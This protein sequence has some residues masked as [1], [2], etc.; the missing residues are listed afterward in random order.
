[1][2]HLKKLFIVLIAVAMLLSGA[3]FRTDVRADEGETAETTEVKEGEA[4][5]VTEAE[6]TIEV[7]LQEEPEDPVIEV[8]E[9][10]ALAEEKQEEELPVETETTETPVPEIVVEEVPVPSEEPAAEVAEE[11]ETVIEVPAEAELPA[12]TEETV[13]EETKEELPAAAPLAVPMLKTEEV[14]SGEDYAYAGLNE[15][16]NLFFFRSNTIYENDRQ[17]SQVEDTDGNTMNNIRVFTGVEDTDPNALPWESYKNDITDAWVY[18]AYSYT[19]APKSTQNWFKDCSNLASFSSIGFDFNNVT[20]SRSMFEGCTSLQDVSVSGI[21]ENLTDMGRMFYEC[22]SLGYLDMSGFQ[23]TSALN[24]MA[25]A[26]EGCI[27]LGGLSF[28]SID[29]SGVT[30]MSGLFRECS[31]MEWLDISCFD[32]RNVTTMSQMFYICENLQN[33][34]YGENFKTSK[35]GNMSAM[36]GFCES[37]TDSSVEIVSTFDTSKVGTMQD[38][39]YDCKNLT[40]LDVSNFYTSNVESMSTMFGSCE[41]LTSL[42]VSGFDTSKVTLIYSMFS[43]CKNLT[44]L[45]VSGFDVSKVANYGLQSMFQGCE[46]LNAIDV[47]DWDVSGIQ[48]FSSMFEGCK[49]LTSLDLGKWN[50]QNG[51]YFGNMFRDTSLNNIVLSK[52]IAELNGAALPA[53]TWTDGTLFLDAYALTEGYAEHAEEWAGTWTRPVLPAASISGDELQWEEYSGAVWYSVGVG[54]GDPSSGDF[55]GG[56][57]PADT[58]SIDLWEYCAMYEMSPGEITVI[59]TAL[60]EGGEELSETWVGYYQYD[61]AGADR[62]LILFDLNGVTD[63]EVMMI[64][65]VQINKGQRR[66]DIDIDQYYPTGVVS[67]V[68]EGWCF[69][70]EGTNEIS[71]SY[72][73][74]ENMTLYA[75]WKD[76]VDPIYVTFPEITDGMNEGDYPYGEID[77]PESNGRYSLDD[78]AWALE[79]GDS[80]DGTFE[81]GNT[82]Y[83]VLSLMIE[84]ND[85]LFPYNETEG[86]T[87]TLY[88]NGD[89]E[90]GYIAD[91]STSY[92]NV[93]IPFRLIDTKIHNLRIDEEGILH[94]DLFPGATYYH[95]Q[96]D[97]GV[98]Y[99]GAGAYDGYYDIRNGLHSSGFRTGDYTIT[100]IAEDAR[101]HEV[102]QGEIVYHYVNDSLSPTP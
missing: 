13:I 2:D 91:G 62:A 1:M 24:Y 36:Y 35:V 42:D 93:R 3:V 92:L 45:D 37:L 102:A 72:A 77:L 76:A 80:F 38:M 49:A 54:I 99:V 11:T 15:D 53:G 56:V 39:F 90:D 58:L 8:T 27:S 48:N 57:V 33:I 9:G 20:S 68:F 95:V 55:H 71:Y 63:P 88:V 98:H 86:G 96:Y 44:T 67:K 50:A 31:S 22:S 59:L 18:S 46:K 10:S 75:K 81:G 17:Y 21:W 25:Q 78:M 89:E 60:N 83:L 94:W 101:G 23:T 52:D 32:T 34:Y 41:S 87:F 7:T 43:N 16:G 66:G 5:E 30:S 40:Q 74:N 64:H 4:P 29:T 14:R 73:V 51:I 79:N 65:S 100:V 12:E 69:D 19:I 82:Y 85:Y 84:D 47:S 61:P 70:P 28:S 97:D 26:F 6:E